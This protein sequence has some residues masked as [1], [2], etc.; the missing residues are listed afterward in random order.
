MSSPPLPPGRVEEQLPDH[1]PLY[2][3]GEAKAES[4]RCLYCYDAP[5]VKAC[6]TAIDIPGFIRRIAG[7]NAIGAARRILEANLLGYSC[8][9][10]C[11]VEV[12]CEG[13]CVYHD[14]KRPP[15]RIG[16]L[17]RYAVETAFDAGRATLPPLRRAPRGRVA[18]VG[19]GPAS[20]ACAG[21][22][23][24]AG[25]ETVL[26]EKRA[27]PG[28]LNTTGVAPY[29]MQAPDS[30]REV[31]FVQSLGVRVETGREVGKDPTADALLRDFD[32]VFLGMG[33]GADQHLGLPGEDGAG[34]CGAT[35]LI[36]RMKNDPSLRLGKVGHVVVIGGGNTALDAARELAQLGA[37]DVT[38][39]YRRGEPEMTGYAHELKCARL[40][41][42]RL[43][44]RTV[45]VEIVREDGRVRWV[46]IADA[47]DG[48]A[49]PGTERLLPAEFVVL[50]IG[51][52][53]LGWVARLFPD[54]AVAADGRITADAEGRTG[55][56]KVYA[57]GD[58][59]NGGDL[60]V[61]AVAAGQRAA[62][63]MLARLGHG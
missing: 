53:K 1:A 5:C 7:D 54:V 22:L 43:F 30:L 23:A 34:V 10:V 42:A 33:L 36:E 8:A 55:N 45:A 19:A 11:P 13:A 28:G 21:T 3:P 12:L 40:E 47:R 60:V 56:V 32:Y 46:R 51:Q 14:W 39:L 16:R 25:V 6:P 9:R 20:L 31:A 38:V 15:I 37:A 24:R 26:F 17:Q 35:A 41:G 2:T 52:A 27:L 18:L 4:D 62:R 44:E 58:C 50:A 48:R 29:K 49:V 57:G 59:V 63:S 61:T